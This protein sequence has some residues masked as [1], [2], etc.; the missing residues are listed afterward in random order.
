[1]VRRTSATRPRR[2]SNHDGKCA[3]SVLFDCCVS[4]ILYHSNVFDAFY[5][6]DSPIN[7]L[8]WLAE[9][10]T[11]GTTMM[12]AAEFLFV[13]FAVGQPFCCWLTDACQWRDVDNQQHVGICDMCGCGSVLSLCVALFT[14]DV[15][16]RPIQFSKI[17]NSCSWSL[18]CEFDNDD[19]GIYTGGW[20]WGYVVYCFVCCHYLWALCGCRSANLSSTQLFCCDHGH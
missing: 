14:S 13:L 3:L 6:T 10:R 11:T 19:N 18:R 17:M 20:L 5:T 9:T 15:G 2:R 7:W 8:R 16:C 4:F 12:M 1:M